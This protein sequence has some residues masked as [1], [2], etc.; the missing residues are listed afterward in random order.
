MPHKLWLDRSPKFEWEA[1]LA[2]ADVFGFDLAFRT[3]RKP[4]FEGSL[5]DWFGRLKVHNYP[6]GVAWECM[7]SQRPA[8]EKLP[9]FDMSDVNRMLTLLVIDHYHE[10][11]HPDLR[12]T[13]AQ[14]WRQGL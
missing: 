4:S 1:L 11:V 12:C 5:E 7:D 14:K 2:A 13:P 3:P 9:V 10:Q 8:A 6:S